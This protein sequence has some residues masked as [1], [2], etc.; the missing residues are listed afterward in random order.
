MK[1]EDNGSRREG[2]L[3]DQCTENGSDTSEGL[4]N[5]VEN[6]SLKTKE[7]VSEATLW[8]FHRRN[9]CIVI[10]RAT[11]NA[12]CILPLGNPCRSPSPAVS[13]VHF[14]SVNLQNI[15]LWELP[16]EKGCKISFS[17]QYKIYGE[18]DWKNKKECQNITRAYCDL[19]NETADSEEYYYARVRA[20]SRAGFSDW[21]KSGRFNPKVETTISSPKVEVK[22]G[23]CSI[24]ITLTAPKKWKTNNEAEAISLAKIFHD[25][26]YNLSVTNRKTNKS[27]IFLE[28][29]NFK[30][31]DT[32]DHDTTYCVTAQTVEFSFHRISEPSETVCA[33]T[34]KD[35]VKQMIKMILLGC[36]LPV[37]VSIFLFTLLGCFM[38]KYVYISDQKQPVN[39]LLQYRPSKAFI[40]IPPE[41]LKVN[42][43]VLENTGKKALSNGCIDAGDGN[44][45]LTSLVSSK[46]ANEWK[47]LPLSISSSEIVYKSQSVEKPTTKECASSS[48]NVVQASY[49]PQQDNHG[50]QSHPSN[51]RKTPSDVQYGIIVMENMIQP[52]QQQN[53]Q[54]PSEK[55]TELLK[56]GYKSQLATEP[57]NRNATQHSVAYSFIETDTTRGPYCK[58]V[59]NSLNGEF[60]EPQQTIY[61]HCPEASGMNTQTIV[62]DTNSTRFGLYGP[63]DLQSE[64]LYLPMMHQELE[65]CNYKSQFQPQLLTGK[66]ILCDD[67]HCSGIML[68]N[69]YLL[70]EE[71]RDEGEEPDTTILDW[72]INTGRLTIPDSENNSFLTQAAGPETNLLSSLYTKDL[73]DE[74]IM[75]EEDNCISQFQKH[76]TLHV[77]T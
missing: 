45:L 68:S 10:L 62:N 49:Q 37:F 6:S 15:V 56:I 77:Q 64:T 38:Y 39:L 33:T 12:I 3:E 55:S 44:A 22:A 1:C 19:S 31:V 34:P 51:G 72:D 61:T 63:I 46:S 58:Q 43:M 73:S 7:D 13:N 32:L 16:R 17:V 48:E 35:P 76:W 50:V 25:L 27:L 30:K 74:S 65:Q 2:K 23:V 28:D 59:F 24:S 67:D 14:W 52:Q 41:P 71:Q 57:L 21:N 9:V 70:N 69:F 60:D 11:T 18:K 53:I 66:T 26:K 29:G 40:F 75:A 54:L 8:K 20:I 42:V 36:V 5:P 4:V 47:G